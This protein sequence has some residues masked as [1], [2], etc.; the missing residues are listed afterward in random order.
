MRFQYDAD[1]IVFREAAPASVALLTDAF[2]L[3]Q[4]ISA[5]DEDAVIEAYIAA[6]TGL[7]DGWN[8]WLSRALISQAWS[9]SIAGPT[10]GKIYAPLS[11]VQSL[12]AVSYYDKNGILQ[13]LPAS[14]FRVIK[15]ADWA[16]IEPKAGVSWPPTESR[17]DAIKATFICGYGEAS[18]DIP[19]ELRQAIT[20]LAGHFYEHREAST[21]LKLEEAPFGVKALI[22]GEK[23]GYAG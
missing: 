22:A 16:Y 8:G 4:R 19:P 9:I 2:K 23:L 14:S 3:S 10:N 18:T 6:A 12:G 1:A 15:S 20:L 7:L 21:M 17:P 11:P 13:A 5:S